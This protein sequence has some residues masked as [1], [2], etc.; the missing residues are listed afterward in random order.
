MNKPAILLLLAIMAWPTLSR[1]AE[2]TPGP[3][4]FVGANAGWGPDT[5]ARGEGSVGIRLQTRVYAVT[6]MNLAG[7]V[8]A[9]VQD[10]LYQ[11]ATTRGVTLWARGGGGATLA[12][13]GDLTSYSPTFGGG[14]MLAYDLAKISERLRGLEMTATVKAMNTTTVRT[15]DGVAETVSY[16]R[17][18]YFMGLKF[19]WE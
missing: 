9:V 8:G 14:V 7:G 5:G 12:R 1:P 17:P 10:I 3:A 11:A 2:P 6:S 4:Y 13:G 16:T 18:Q 19:N 15:V